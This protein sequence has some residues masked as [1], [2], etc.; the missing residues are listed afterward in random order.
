[1]AAQEALHKAAE[2][3]KAKAREAKAA[4]LAIADEE[5]RQTAI[6]AAEKAE[7]KAVEDGV[8]AAEEAKEAEHALEVS[9]LAA[10]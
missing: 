4:A 3:D 6:E 1:M 7:K 9:A 10:K 5:K 8:K 2:D